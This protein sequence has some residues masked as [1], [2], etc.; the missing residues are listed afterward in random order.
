[1]FDLYLYGSLVAA[2]FKLN[3]RA[4]CPS[5]SEVVAQIECDVWQV[6]ASVARVVFVALG[7]VVAVEAL[8]VEI[9]CHDGLAIS[10]DAEPPGGWRFRTRCRCRVNGIVG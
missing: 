1:M 3:L 6:E 10:A 9:A 8:A 7:R 2:M 5:V 4:E